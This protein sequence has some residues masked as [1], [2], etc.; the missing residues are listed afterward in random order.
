MSETVFDNE[1]A[2]EPGIPAEL[3]TK[4]LR[5]WSSADK[6]KYLAQ[7]KELGRASGMEPSL[8]A[9]EPRVEWMNV[10]PNMNAIEEQE[11]TGFLYATFEEAE[12]A[13]G[14]RRIAC[15]PVATHLL[16]DGSG[17]LVLREDGTV[18]GI[19]TVAV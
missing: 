1:V 19:A 6:V 2:G 15:L 4:P 7:L 13:A 8:A 12:R 10:Y 11:L 9:A 17:I 18:G 5:Q 3:M 16:R 14:P